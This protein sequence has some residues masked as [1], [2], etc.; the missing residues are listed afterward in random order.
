MVG[1]FVAVG[2]V[3]LV[4]AIALGR[5]YWRRKK[6]RRY[7]DHD[8]FV[9][10][11]RH[12]RSTR[13]YQDDNEKVDGSVVD[14]SPTATPLAMAAHDAY[15]S[16]ETHYGPT[17]GFNAEQYYDSATGHGLEYPPA[18]GGEQNRMSTASNHAG[19]GVYGIAATPVSYV[20]QTPAI[21]I[22]G[23]DEH[24]PAVA[25]QQSPFIVPSHPTRPSV[26]SLYLTD[27]MAH[28]K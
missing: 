13:P 16:R 8:I 21:N 3:A 14:I 9:Q 20:P 1:T 27:S 2:V 7:D 24:G 5:C 28:A 18:I 15:P 4:I 23:P 6:A 17:G 12:P 25:E 19:Y 11:S 22:Q 26:D 10:Q